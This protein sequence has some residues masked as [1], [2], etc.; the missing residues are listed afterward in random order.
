[1]NMVGTQGIDGDEE[2]VRLRRLLGGRIRSVPPGGQKRR[3]KKKSNTPH[4]LPD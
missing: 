4:G 2:Y 3:D 1:M